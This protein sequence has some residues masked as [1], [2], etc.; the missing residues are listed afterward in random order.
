MVCLTISVIALVSHDLSHNEGLTDWASVGLLEGA[1]L[2][3]LVSSVELMHWPF[4]YMEDL[5]RNCPE[6]LR[7]LLFLP[8]A[9]CCSRVET[10][11]SGGDDATSLLNAVEHERSTV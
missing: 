8:I 7:R 6:A 10:W 9:A 5:V 4:S 11:A 1:R 2:V 3:P